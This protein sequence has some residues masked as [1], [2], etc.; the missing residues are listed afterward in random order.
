MRFRKA[1]T[2]FDDYYEMMADRVRMEA[3]RKAIFK[4]VKE[5]DVVVDLGAGLGILS[6]FALQ[7]GARRVYAIEKME[8]IH[9]AEQVA[10]INGLA[11]RMVFIQGNSKDVELEERADCL[12][13]ETLG[14]FALE[15]NTLDFTIDARD[16]FLKEGAK[17]VP[18]RLELWL[19]PVDA[20][21]AY[22][23]MEFWKDIHGIDFGPAREELLRRLIIAEID[24]RSLLS[25]PKVFKEIDLY[26]VNDP[27]I[28]GRVEFELMKAGT[29]YGFGGWF[30][31]WLTEGIWIDTSPSSPLTHW[32]QAFFP[33]RRPIRV[34]WGDRVSLDLRVAPGREDDTTISYDCIYFPGEKKEVGRNDPCPCGS[35]RKYKRC[36]GR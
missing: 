8:S 30:K 20:P 22:E 6:F 23:R 15:E 12:L 13:S 24:K 21:R 9:L 2:L 26:R 11:S 3:Y 28:K 5:G 1:L 4:V 25:S 36:C 27:V 7:A 17:M 34:K 31:A 33:L 16:R 19:A 18:E 10:R 14:S 32:K 35:G 29:L